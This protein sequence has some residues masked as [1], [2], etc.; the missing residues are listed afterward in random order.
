MEYIHMLGFPDGFITELG[1]AERRLAH[2]FIGTSVILGSCFIYLGGIGSRRN[3][4]KKLYAAIFLYLISII[5]MSLM[6]YYYHLHL[7]D[8]A[9]G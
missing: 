6:D 2:I 3:I 8:S 9:G 7:T 4:G 5:S 1:Y